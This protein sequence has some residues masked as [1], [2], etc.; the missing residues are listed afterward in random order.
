MK[1][2]RRGGT[3]V[4]DLQGLDGARLQIAVKKLI[5]RLPKGAKAEI[6]M[7]DP[8]TH[9]PLIM[10]LRERCELLYDRLDGGTFRIG[11]RK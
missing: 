6:V 5:S 1:L 9:E 11:V 2:T 8:D 4:A 3:V 7:D 10:A